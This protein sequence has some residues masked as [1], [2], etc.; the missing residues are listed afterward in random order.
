MYEQLRL[1][2]PG[3][4]CLRGI[5]GGNRRAPPGCIEVRPGLYRIAQVE[6]TDPANPELGWKLKGDDDA[7]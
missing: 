1:F 6:L 4:P 5:N 2:D 3:P 7:A